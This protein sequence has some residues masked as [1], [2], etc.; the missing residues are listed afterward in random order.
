M[1]APYGLKHVYW[2]IKFDPLQRYINSAESASTTTS[3]TRREGTRDE[4]R[5]LCLL[6]NNNQIIKYF[7]TRQRSMG[8]VFVSWKYLVETIKTAIRNS[9]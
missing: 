7:R 9:I 4:I 5:F 6:W 3:I 2:T 8:H 1:Q